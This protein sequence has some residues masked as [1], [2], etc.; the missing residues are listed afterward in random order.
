MFSSPETYM[1]FFFISLV[2]SFALLARTIHKNKDRPPTKNNNWYR[3]LLVSVMA[4]SIFG[5]LS[6]LFQF[7][8]E[9]FSYTQEQ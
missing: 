7:S 3:W 6:A 5:F 2:G 8:S 9:I 4:L 1:W